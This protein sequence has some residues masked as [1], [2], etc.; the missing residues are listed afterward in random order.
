MGTAQ[1]EKPDNSKIFMQNQKNDDWF[2][3]PSSK[4]KKFKTDEK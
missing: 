1:N 2:E 3:M 4:K